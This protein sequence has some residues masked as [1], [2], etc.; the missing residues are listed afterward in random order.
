MAFKSEAQRRK[1]AELVKQG[2]LSQKVFDE[3]NAA[4]KGKI[5]EKVQPKPPKNVKIIK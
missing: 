1:F 4:T 5:P 2:K 3:F